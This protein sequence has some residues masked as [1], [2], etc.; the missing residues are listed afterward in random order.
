LNVPLEDDRTKESWGSDGHLRF[1]ADLLRTR[2]GLS[3]GNTLLTCGNAE[4]Q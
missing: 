4:S 2:R 1:F 3:P